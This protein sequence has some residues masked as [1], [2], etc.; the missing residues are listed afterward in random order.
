MR[1]RVSLSCWAQRRQSLVLN[2]ST[3]W[4]WPLCCMAAD[5]PP[6]RMPFTVKGTASMSK[7]R[8]KALLQ[9]QARTQALIALWKQISSFSSPSVSMC[10]KHARACSHSPAFSQALMTAVWQILSGINFCSGMP[11]RMP[12]AFC[13][14][15]AFSQ[16]LSSELNVTEFAG[17]VDL[18]MSF[19]RSK[20]KFQR[21]AAA[22]ALQAA[23][24]VMTSGMHP[25]KRKSS[26]SWSA[27]DHSPPFAQALMAALY[28]T[29]LGNMSSSFI[30][31]RR[32]S[33]ISHFPRFSHA[34]MTLVK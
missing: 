19:N 31:S 23:L 25:S 20:D 12:M 6:Q 29:W 7:A 22:Q 18:Y 32:V 10:Q 9:A 2:E 14:C 28:V 3:A 34:L 26:K 33:D 4:P 16:A 8:P 5:T 27:A 1:G 17:M 30:L 15:L 13:H 24:Y 11:K 21:P